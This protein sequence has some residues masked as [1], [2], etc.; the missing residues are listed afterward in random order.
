[1]YDIASNATNYRLAFSDV[2]TGAN[3]SCTTCRATAGYDTPTGLGTPN[4]SAL[5]ALL[6]N[7]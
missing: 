1:L 7:R 6:Q 3:G 5:L 2:M 4:V